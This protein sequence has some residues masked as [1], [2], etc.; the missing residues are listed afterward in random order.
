MVDWLRKEVRSLRWT[1]VLGWLLLVLIAVAS[2]LFTPALRNLSQLLDRLVPSA[3]LGWRVIALAAA[4]VLVPLAAGGAA[5]FVLRAF[6]GRRD[7][8]TVRRLQD[9]LFAEVEPGEFRGYQVAM[10]AWPNPTV[11]TLA[12][13]TATFSDADS[14]GKL[15]ALYLPGTPDPAKGTLKV[16]PVDDLTFLDWTVED[17]WD[18]HLTFGSASPEST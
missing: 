2:E 16:G 6:Q 8:E 17:L 18:F 12:L 14:G 4:L 13:V 7:V 9:R 15:A 5:D 1:Y 3:S 10:V 11:R